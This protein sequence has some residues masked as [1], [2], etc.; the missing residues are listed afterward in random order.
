MPQQQ[1]AQRVDARSPMCSRLSA[2]CVLLVLLCVAACCCMCVG[3]CRNCVLVP[4]TFKFSLALRARRRPTPQFFVGEGARG[5]R[6][7]EL[8]S[9]KVSRCSVRARVCCECCEVRRLTAVLLFR[10]ISDCV[11]ILVL[12]LA[13]VLAV[14]FWLAAGVVLFGSRQLHCA[15][16]SWAGLLWQPAWSS[17]WRRGLAASVVVLCSRRLR[18]HSSRRSN[19]PDSGSRFPV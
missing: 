14:V 9:S 5:N 7:L 11:Q 18:L 12:V 15:S 13:L 6:G 4:N 8:H 2:M 3:V 17:L 10:S 1:L 19:R 16:L